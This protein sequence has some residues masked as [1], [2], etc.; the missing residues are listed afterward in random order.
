[1]LADSVADV[2]VAGRPEFA[3]R[4]TYSTAA[5]E[6]RAHFGFGGILELDRR[7][8]VVVDGVLYTRPG[9]GDVLFPFG[10]RDDRFT[11]QGGF[12]LEFSRSGP[13]RVLS[14]GGDV[15]VFSWVDPWTA[16]LSRVVS[17]AAGMVDLAYDDAGQL[18]A[19]SKST[20][21][22]V[23]ISWESGRIVGLSLAEP[24]SA[25]AISLLHYEYNARDEL[26]GIVD[27]YGNHQTFTYDEAHRMVARTDRSG[28]RFEY[29][30]D[31]AGRCVRAGGHDGVAQV[32]LRY[33]PEA[34]ATLVTRA[35]G[36]EW[37]HL[38][39][40]DGSI[41]EI[42]D[43]L[44]GKRSFTYG[45]DGRLASETDPAGNVRSPLQDDTGEVIAWRTKGGGLRPA[46]SPSGPL[47]HRVPRSVCEL[48][49]GYHADRITSR[50]S[51]ASPGIRPLFLHG[52]SIWSQLFSERDAKV[53]DR[54]RRDPGGLLLS[55]DRDG[56]SARRWSYTPNGWVRRYQDHEG[57]RYEF[58]YT[59]W[60]H[61]KSA[62]DPLGRT[63]RY[64][65]TPTERISAIVDPLGNRHEY[66]YDLTDNLTHVVHAGELVETYH[67]DQA[68]NLIEKR[69]ASGQTLVTYEYGADNLKSRRVFAD[70][71][72]HR[73]A[74]T[75]EGKFKTITFGQHHLEFEYAANGRRRS[76]LRDGR[77]VTHRFLG[78]Q[79]IE[80]TILDRFTIRYERK[81]ERT[82]IITDPTGSQ[83]TVEIGDD[84]AVHRHFAD[85]STEVVHYDSLGRCLGKHL[86]PA[87]TRASVWRRVYEYSP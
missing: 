43:P 4:R 41:V 44:G 17:S 56:S 29:D 68:G 28:Y 30:F 32:T 70:G 77:G 10:P 11:P 5:L 82:L 80:T 71:E 76:D 66:R 26:I 64:E 79:L 40:E 2:T 8:R 39:D 81:D 35:D 60:N 50:A 3:W 38:Y 36:G 87:D 42:I 75:P 73:Y 54:C 59:S 18:V 16:R 57:R 84:G 83:H 67:H 31:S 74:Y 25:R 13:L 63:I 15:D 52:G 51:L 22:R 85:G 9:A 21:S 55:E 48:E 65:Y 6:C 61:R 72:E 37:L 1:M 24:G 62:R 34:R 53:E 14:S 49:Y 19:A 69:D 23:R 12:R 58:S 27:H 7:L 45:D 33:M 78:E 86:F 47:P 20:G 46:S